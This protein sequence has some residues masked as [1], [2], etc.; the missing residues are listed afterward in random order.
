MAR[1]EG[2]A[3]S[4]RSLVESASAETLTE[5]RVLRRLSCWRAGRDSRASFARLRNEAKLRREPP[6]SL[7]SHSSLA[8]RSRLPLRFEDRSKRKK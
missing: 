1:R 5:V 6:W 3:C 7:R 2:F 4:L 8:D